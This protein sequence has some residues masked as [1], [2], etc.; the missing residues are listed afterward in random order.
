ML[1]RLAPYAS[2]AHLVT[3]LRAWP[4]P[5][6]ASEAQLQAL[7]QLVPHTGTEALRVL[8]THMASLMQRA[9]DAACDVLDAV[10]DATLP[11]GLDPFTPP[12]HGS[13][14]ARSTTTSTTR[15][16]RRPLGIV[17]RNATRRT[18]YVAS[19]ASS[20]ARV[21]ACSHTRAW[22]D[23]ASAWRAAH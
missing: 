3:L 15:R 9:S 23:G 5:A 20:H 1:A 13:L 16:K 10:L 17:H 21:V 19:S 6:E 12:T 14:A 22:S 7:A 18:R 8:H 2:E 11:P 4:S